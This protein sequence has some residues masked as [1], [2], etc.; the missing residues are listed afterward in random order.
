[1]SH[2]PYPQEAELDEGSRRILESLPPLNIVRM[3]AG[4]PAALKP[5]TDLGAAILLHAE[6]DARIRQVAVLTIARVTE[7]EYERVQHENVARVV[8][9][10][11]EVIEALAAGD[12]RPLSAEYRL[13][14]R[15]A[16][17]IALNV[18]ADP[19]LTAEVLEMIGRRHTTELV[20][21]C[22]YYSA[23]ARIIET[24][25][26]KVEDEV[27]SASFTPADADPGRWGHPDDRGAS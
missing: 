4:A 26:V 20:V 17:Q 27:P 24:C 15:Y 18:R 13:I 10:S 25:G 23:V 3:F 16:E 1:M 11:D 9:L 8:G 6:L 14:A 21:C 19:A 22:G 2:I 7:C 5:L 12:D